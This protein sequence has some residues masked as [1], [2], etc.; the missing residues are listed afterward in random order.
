MSTPLALLMTTILLAGNAF[1]VGAEF[2]GLGQ[3]LE[4]AAA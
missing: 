1:F 2:A 4:L 3:W